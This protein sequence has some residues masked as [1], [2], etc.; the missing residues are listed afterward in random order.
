[1]SL[2]RRRNDLRVNLAPALALSPATKIGLVHFDLTIDDIVGF[3][4]QVVANDLTQTMKIVNG[5]LRIDANQRC[6]TSRRRAGY[7]MFHQPVLFC[8]AQS[9]LPHANHNNTSLA[10]SGSAPR[11]IFTFA[12]GF[13]IGKSLQ[14]RVFVHVLN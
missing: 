13:D 3:K 1:M 7:K 11:I 5:S 6:R 4:L 14:G 2:T 8:L 10:L 9:A 12:V